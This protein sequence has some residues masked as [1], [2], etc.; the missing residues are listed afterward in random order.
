[1]PYDKAQFQK[2]IA[3]VIAVFGERQPMGF[4]V[5]GRY[6][7]GLFELTDPLVKRQKL[8]YDGR[9]YT[10]GMVEPSKGVGKWLIELALAAEAQDEAQETL[11]CWAIQR[12]YYDSKNDVLVPEVW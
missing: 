9:E 6:E 12:R 1:M 3:M 2:D 8:V 10:A 7:D 11:N 4:Y 5:G